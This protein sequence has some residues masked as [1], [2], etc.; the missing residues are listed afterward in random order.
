[1]DRAALAGLSGPEARDLAELLTDDL[2]D[3]G[4]TLLVPAGRWNVYLRPGDHV[5]AEPPQRVPDAE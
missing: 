3:N 2:L 4:G 5:E 1:M